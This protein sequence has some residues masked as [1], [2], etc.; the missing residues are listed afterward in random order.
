[1]AEDAPVPRLMGRGDAP[2]P[3]HHGQAEAV[4][5]GTGTGT[6]PRAGTTAQELHSQ[7]GLAGLLKHGYFFCLYF[8]KHG[9]L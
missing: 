2:A 4:G 5:C 1:M 7:H 3:L 9:L 8:N 6:Q